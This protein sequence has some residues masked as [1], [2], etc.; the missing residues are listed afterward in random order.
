MRNEHRRQYLARSNLLKVLSD[1]DVANVSSAE[2][3]ERLR[4]GD[5]YLDLAHL[6]HG[7]RRARGE[8]TPS[9][10]VLPKKAVR[11]QTWKR[12]LAQLTVLERAARESKT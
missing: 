5:V 7:L 6:E 8:T 4:D 12:I 10:P 2:T 3:A 11:E 9:G 1:E